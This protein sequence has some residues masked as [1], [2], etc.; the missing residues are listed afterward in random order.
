MKHWR[1]VGANAFK[2]KKGHHARWCPFLRVL[3]CI[4]SLQSRGLGLVTKTLL[5]AV[6]LHA[7][8]AL[9]LADLCLTAF[10]Q[11][12]HGIGSLVVVLKLALLCEQA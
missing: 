4:A 6:R 9:V 10:F 11:T 3:A 7:L 1:R 12:S 5:M 8:L 2:Q